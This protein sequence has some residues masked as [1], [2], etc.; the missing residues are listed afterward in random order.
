MLYLVIS[1]APAPEGFPALVRAVEQAGWRVAVFS[2]PDGA[3]FADIV[4]LE[5]L[6][7]APVRWEYRS[8]GTGPTRECSP[9]LPA[10]LQLGE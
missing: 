4:E 7:G 9:R 6:T 10:D 5:R 8:P 2:T 1:A 3:S